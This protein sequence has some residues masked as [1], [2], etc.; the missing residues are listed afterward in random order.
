MSL[1]AWGLNGFFGAGLLPG[2]PP[3]SAKTKSELPAKCIY[4]FS[5]SVH[6]KRMRQQTVAHGDKLFWL[7]QAS[8][9][10]A[11]RACVDNELEM[12]RRCLAS[13]VNIYS[14]CRTQTLSAP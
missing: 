4:S 9:R 7:A 13:D 2:V 3:A 10:R 14:D 8:S 11:G 12:R 5:T 6:R 1:G